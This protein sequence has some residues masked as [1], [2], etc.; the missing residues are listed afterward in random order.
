MHRSSEH[1]GSG[2]SLRCSLQLELGRGSCLEVS[3]GGGFV[4]SL[5][6]LVSE[7]STGG[8]DPVVCAWSRVSVVFL[9]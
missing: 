4:A 8:A 6:G 3:R 5:H 9:A 1:P 2:R 7:S